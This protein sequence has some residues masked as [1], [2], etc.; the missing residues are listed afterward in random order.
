MIE[1]LR[2]VLGCSKKQE[3][4]LEDRKDEV[5]EQ[6]SVENNSESIIFNDGTNI[7]VEK[8]SDCLKE[9]QT[10]LLLESLE[11]IEETN[12]DGK[13]NSKPLKVEE[14]FDKIHKRHFS[15]MESITD[16]AHKSKKLGPQ[17][18]QSLKKGPRKVVQNSRHKKTSPKK[19]IVFDLQKSLQKPLP[20]KPYTGKLKPF[21]Q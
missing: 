11:T 15:E 3:Q 2:Q 18:E 12:I 13:E 6:L 19:K 14:K 16:V 10:L 20:Y 21:G 5:E 4:L 17:K 9:D 7:L 1:S 8:K